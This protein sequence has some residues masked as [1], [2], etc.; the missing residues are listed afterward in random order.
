MVRTEEFLEV[1]WIKRWAQYAP[2]S[3]A[4]ES[5]DQNVTI[6]YF[7]LHEK[8]GITASF[9]QHE[10]EI[11]AGDRVAVLSMNRYEYIVLFFALQKLGAIL[12]PLNYRL[13]AP[14]L[15]YQLEDATPSLLIYEEDYEATV[16]KT[17]FDGQII[18]FDAFINGCDKH[19]SKAVTFA[20]H[21]EYTCKILY[22][23]GTTGRPKG[24][25]I[26]NKM[27]FWNSINTGLRLNLTQ[28]DVI[29]TFAPFFHTGGWNVL[30]TPILHRG[31]KVVLLKKF[32]PDQVLELC[33]KHK[34]SVLFGVPTMMAMLADEASFENTDLSSIRYAI[35][36]GEPMPIP[37]IEKWHH[38]G[39]PVRQGYGLTEFGPNVF[40]LNEE[41]AI[42]KKGSVGFAN[43]YIDTKIVNDDGKEVQIGEVGELWLKGPVCT[44]GYWNNPNATQETI[45]QGW[46]KTGDLVRKDEEGYFF[47]VDRKKDMFIS[48][49]ENV[50]PAEIEQ[51]L[52]KHKNVKEVAVIGVPDETWGEVGMAFVVTEFGE[53]T[54]DELSSYCKEYLAKFK[55]PK[56]FVFMVELP[57]SDTGK[58][59]KK[60][61]KE[62]INQNKSFN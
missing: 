26:T 2:K 45:E 6:T 16:K 13:A 30:T 34:V 18:Q 32:E 33:A 23:S 10:Y 38:K 28:Q 37:L 59:Q 7:E 43:F 40:S 14:E 1:D 5:V 61:L 19:E 4:I 56:H 15:A 22:T 31:G 12:L 27:L 47:I 54:S 35:V 8:V 42:R 20:G 3:V 51:L 36:G 11:E 60:T 62:Y 17:E 29:L 55:V 9:L 49:A 44:E 53:L 58:I 21:F 57:K 25:I 52:V 39:V 50:Y 46:L 24:A 41:D 48:G